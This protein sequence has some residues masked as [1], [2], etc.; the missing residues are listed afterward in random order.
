MHSFNYF[1]HC[2]TT[3][4]QHRFFFKSQWGKKS[5]IGFLRSALSRAILE[6]P[7]WY[8]EGA[9]SAFRI[10][11]CNTTVSHYVGFGFTFDW[12]HNFY[13]FVSFTSMLLISLY[14]IPEVFSWTQIWWQLKSAKLLVVIMRP[15]LCSICI[16]TL[17]CWK[18]PFGKLIIRG[19]KRKHM[20]SNDKQIAW[21]IYTVT[22]WY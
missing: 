5:I 13:K 11:Y 2:W 1:I 18:L 15:V 12:M 22:G 21:S 9:S 4:Q 14:C 20:I 7:Y 8:W 17:L 6:T 16:L 19:H 10:A 3:G